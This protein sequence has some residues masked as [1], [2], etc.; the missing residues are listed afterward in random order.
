[1]KNRIALFLKG[2][3]H[4]YS[5]PALTARRHRWHRYARKPLAADTINARI[6]YL[7]QFGFHVVLGDSVYQ[8]TGFLAGTPESRAADF[9]S[10]ITN[11]A[12]KWILP[13]RG[14]VGV[15]G[16]LPYLDYDEIRANPKIVS[17]YSD[18]TIL[19]NVLSQY[20][21]LLTFQGLLLT[22]FQPSTPEYNFTSFFSSVMTL[23]APRA[24]QNPD[25][26]P[27]IGKVPGVASGEIVG[28]NLTSFVDSIG[29]PYEID[30]AGKIIVLEDTNESINTIY[31]YLAHLEAAGKFA[32]CAAIVMGTCSNCSIAYNTSYDDLIEGFLVPLGKP[33]LSNLQ[34]AH[35]QYKVCVPIG[36]LARV[37]GTNATIT[38]LDR[39]VR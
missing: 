26:F 1:M 38:I 15:A 4:G 17:G 11:N 2:G 10:M 32:D 9:M 3:R 29:T 22:D 30:T 28:G 19:L 27:L 25:G 36:A 20:A 16:I 39:T 5:T 6:Q 34:T 21:D 13:S 7:E 37:D 33:L 24:L 12:V 18:I 23:Q 35:G 8:R 14:G 31:R